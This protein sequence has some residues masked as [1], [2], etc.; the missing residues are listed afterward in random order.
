MLAAFLTTIFFS[1]SVICGNRSAQMIGGSE[2]NFWRLTCATAFLSLY[3]LTLG[4]GLSGASFSIFVASGIIGI[5]VGDVALFQALP[6][7]GSRLTLLLVQCLTAPFG[8]AIE[9]LWLGTELSPMQMF[10]GAVILSGIAISLMPGRG[11]HLQKK[12]ILPGVLFSIV[13]AIAQAYGAV[14]SRKAYA[15]ADEHDEHIDGATAAFQ[16]ILGGL[17]I[18][19]I[20]LLV[21]KWRNIRDHLIREGETLPSKEKWRRVLPWVVANSLAGQTL[22]VSCYQWAFQTTPT[23]I[24]L[25]I[26]ATTPLVAIPFTMAVEKERPSLH[27]IIGGVIAVIGVIGLALVK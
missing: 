14:L 9:W 25:P 26:V 12:A 24:V 10:F 7:L 23:G 16:R 17:L 11:L 4:Q 22:G 3:A 21:V 18:G 5:G 27:S 1:I 8:A 19:G 13:A 2:A 15:V 20:S 6:R